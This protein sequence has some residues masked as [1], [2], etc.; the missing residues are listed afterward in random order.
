MK[1]QTPAAVALEVK[2]HVGITDLSESVGDLVE[3]RDGFRDFVYTE[4][5]A[6]ELAVFEFVMTHADFMEAEVAQLILGA[7][8]H[9]KF[10]GRHSFAVGHTGT[11]ACELRFVGGRKAKL[12]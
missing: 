4:L 3:G 1:I 8:N 7:L 2:G 10:L 5:Y 6:R 11:Q 12:F 9:G